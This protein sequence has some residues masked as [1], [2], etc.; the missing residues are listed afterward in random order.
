M[1][2]PLGNVINRLVGALVALP[3][4]EPAVD[5]LNHFAEPWARIPA[6]FHVMFNLGTAA[7][8][9]AFLPLQAR[10]LEQLLPSKAGGDDQGAPKYLDVASL[11][12]APVAVANA[13]REMMRMADVVDAMLMSSQLAFHE[14]DRD[15]IKAISRQDDVLD[16][17]NDA[18]QRYLAA[19]SAETTASD[20]TQRVGE[21]LSFAINLEHVGDIIDKNL[22]ELAS[23]RIRQ[24]ISLSKEILDEIDDMHSRLRDHL[25]LALTVFM[26]AD[27]D[28]ARRLVE[29][30][31]RFRDFEQTTRERHLYLIGSGKASGLE[32]N[33]LQLDVTRDLKRIE[34]HIATG[35]HTLLQRNGQ[36]RTSR[37]RSQ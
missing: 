33:A 14:N 28:A 37:L 1:R 6:D 13:A 34:A 36:L 2:L 9:Y 26:F 24:Q 3:L 12:D 22:M 19:I 30:K 21:I 4:V 25:K 16:K 31:E 17:L 32:M 7:L 20:E 8:F 11:A 5:L 15:K 27:E 29:E 23:K 35:A 18:I 10:L